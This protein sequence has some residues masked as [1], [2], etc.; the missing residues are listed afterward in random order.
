MRDSSACLRA[1][2]H[3]AFTAWRRKFS[4]VARTCAMS[5]PMEFS[6]S[7]IRTPISSTARALVAWTKKVVR[8]RQLGREGDVGRTPRRSWRAA[9]RA[10]AYC[11]Q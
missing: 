4:M 8:K 2:E 3:A 7:S 9:G 11:G 10:T 5:S 1:C 6:S